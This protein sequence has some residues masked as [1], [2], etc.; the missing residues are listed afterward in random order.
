[1]GIFAPELVVYCAWYQWND[2][3]KL[4]AAISA[5]G[6]AKTNAAGKASSDHTPVNEQDGNETHEATPTLKVLWTQT[7]SFYAI[8]GGFAIETSE[9]RGDKFIEPFTRDSYLPRLTLTSQGVLLLTELGM[10]PMPSLKSIQDRS[11]A[12]NLAKGLVCLQAGWLI[13]QCVS[14]RAAR[15]PI[16]FLEINTL[17][18]VIC[19]LFMYVFWWNKPLDIPEPTLVTNEAIRLLCA[20]MWM[21]GSNYGSCTEELLYHQVA[22]NQNH[23]SCVPTTQYIFRRQQNETSFETGIS[24]NSSSSHQPVVSNAN[25]GDEE[26]TDYS[27]STS[28]GELHR[29]F[30]ALPR[31]GTLIGAPSLGLEISGFT[32]RYFCHCKTP[33]NGQKIDVL[34]IS[35]DFDNGEFKPWDPAKDQLPRWKL[36]DQAIRDHPTLLERHGRLIKEASSP[37]KH[38]TFEMFKVPFD[39][40]VRNMTNWPR[41]GSYMRDW[42]N[43][44]IQW[45]IYVFGLVS[46]QYGGLHATAWNAFF[47]SAAEKLLW[48]ISAS[49]LAALGFFWGIFTA[50][51]RRYDLC[52]NVAAAL[53]MF[54]TVGL[55]TLLFVF[56]RLFLVIEAF[57]S[58]RKLPVEAYVAPSW[59][60]F[61]PHL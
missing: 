32:Q 17:G 39:Y 60:Q 40:L 9:L 30:V 14:R 47:P 27:S 20:F 23:Q 25:E 10:C 29:P 12:S 37:D 44:I 28:K 8:M 33:T 50:A 4:T 42:P 1:M 11:K 53:L 48:R 54:S 19:A 13:L 34:D 59:A 43:M 41:H 58:L 3:R 57:I 5:L 45:P 7:H 31:Y 24:M 35:I 51:D 15:L 21:Y 6:H 36:A 61:I 38:R 55:S 46:A 49:S 16:T 2:A 52:P 26:R 56:A 22:L 18:H